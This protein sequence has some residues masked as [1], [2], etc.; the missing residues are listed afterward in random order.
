MDPPNF[1]AFHTEGRLDFANYLF[2]TIL[3]R[4]YTRKP[5]PQKGPGDLVGRVYLVRFFSAC[6]LFRGWMTLRGDS[7][8]LKNNYFFSKKNF[9]AFMNNFFL[10]RI[11]AFLSNF[12]FMNIFALVKFF[13]FMNNF[14]FMNN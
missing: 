10:K 4:W 2:K 5:Q 6:I 8:T 3:F 14:A 12:S 11:F 13:S 7:L 9:F 1:S